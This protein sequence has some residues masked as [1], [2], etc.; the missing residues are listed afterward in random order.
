MSYMLM[1][2]G[3]PGLF[4]GMLKSPKMMLFLE[5]LNMDEICSGNSSKKVNIVTGCLI[6]YGAL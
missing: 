2:S 3:S 6:E 5:L 1:V 4:Q